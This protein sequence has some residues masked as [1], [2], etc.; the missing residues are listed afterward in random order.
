MTSVIHHFT[1]YGGVGI[2]ILRSEESGRKIIQR[3]V[4]TNIYR[5]VCQESRYGVVGVFGGVAGGFGGVVSFIS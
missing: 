3:S 1:G 2:A 5:F 4:C